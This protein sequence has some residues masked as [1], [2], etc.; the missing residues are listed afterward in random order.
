MISQYGLTVLFVDGFDVLV[1]DSMH[2]MLD[3]FLSM[4]VPL[5][6]QAEKGYHYQPLFPLS[7]ASFIV[8]VAHH[9]S[10]VSMLVIDVGHGYIKMKVS[11]NVLMF[12]LILHHHIVSSIGTLT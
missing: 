3:S 9:L 6:F 7:I 2:G 4:N 10:Y 5:I 11:T 12:I 8:N 1:Y